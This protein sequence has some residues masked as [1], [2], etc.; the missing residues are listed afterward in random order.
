MRALW[1]VLGAL[2]ATTAVGVGSAA[3]LGI[4]GGD[5]NENGPSGTNTPEATGTPSGATSGETLRLL[6][7]DPITMDPACASDVDSAAYVIEIFG[8]LVTI[9]RNLNTV[10]DTAQAIPAPVHTA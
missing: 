5:D 4:G 10:P 6:G 3:A 7:S 8:G 1:L 2:A 9:D